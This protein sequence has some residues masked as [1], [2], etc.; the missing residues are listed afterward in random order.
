M[1]HM[2]KVLEVSAIANCSSGICIEPGINS[3]GKIHYRPQ[4][5]YHN[6][7]LFIFFFSVKLISFISSIDIRSTLSW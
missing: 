3:H 1:Q 6:T 5:G 7:L 4:V 2:Y